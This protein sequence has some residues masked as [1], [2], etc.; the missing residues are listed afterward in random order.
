MERIYARL[1]MKTRA[2]TRPEGSAPPG[3]PSAHRGASLP[4]DGF[5]A[6]FHDHFAPVARASMLLVQDPDLGREIAQE[7]FTRL[8][9]RWH[10]MASLEH[11]RNFVFRVALNLARSHLRRMRRTRLLDFRGYAAGSLREAPGEM[12]RAEAT[13]LVHQ[14]LARLPARQRACLVLIDYLGFDS[15]SAGRMLRIR[16]STL[17]VHLARARQ[18]F[19]DEVGI[20]GSFGESRSEEAE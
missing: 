1:R 2:E 12:D 18:R 3:P 6:F 5:T 14:V 9:V 11:A 19:R 4:E 16:P 20:Q 8:Y 17:R 15:A 7:S 13:I 10:E